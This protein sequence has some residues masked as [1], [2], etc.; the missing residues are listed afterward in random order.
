MH[1]KTRC[2]ESLPALHTIKAPPCSYGRAIEDGL[3]SLA[4]WDVPK[5]KASQQ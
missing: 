4:H 1:V 5:L 3:S 2:L